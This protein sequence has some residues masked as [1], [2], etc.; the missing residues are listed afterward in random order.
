M[1]QE[2]YKGEA[3]CKSIS[4]DG[5]VAL[6]ATGVAAILAGAGGLPCH[7]GFARAGGSY[8]G[9]L[10]AVPALDVGT[11]SAHDCLGGCLRH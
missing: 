8:R 4:L 6:E 5:A 3:I 7:P 11:I 10:G 9:R 2:L 1:F